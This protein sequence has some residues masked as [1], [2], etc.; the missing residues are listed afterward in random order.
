MAKRVSKWEQRARNN[1]RYEEILKD[2]G[3]FI[4]RLEDGYVR[5]AQC[6]ADYELNDEYW[7]V[8]DP[9]NA[10]S[11]EWRGVCEA[12]ASKIWSEIRTNN[13]TRCYVGG[14]QNPTKFAKG[15]EVYEQKLRAE[16]LA[17][18]VK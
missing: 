13:M 2:N 6:R 15:V 14:A 11:K 4:V 10:V 12:I 3:R 1:P 9:E 8:F 17:L 18:G 5:T 7:K 16:L